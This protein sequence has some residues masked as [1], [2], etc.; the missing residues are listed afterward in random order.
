VSDE[1]TALARSD[2]A[3]DALLT[4]LRAIIAS[5]GER[6]STT[7]NAEI[8]ATYWTMGERVAHE[9][10]HGAARAGS[11]TQGGG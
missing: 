2:D 1:S 7:V 11:C 4:D 9:E 5:G 8:V 6:A 10:Q 3:Y